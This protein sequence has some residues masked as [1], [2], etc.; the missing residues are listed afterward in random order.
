[1]ENQTAFVR[2]CLHHPNGASKIVET[3]EEE[4]E[5]RAAGWGDKPTPQYAKPAPAPT[6]PKLPDARCANCE[7]ME[8]KFN[9]A[10]N[11]AMAERKELLAR[12]DE[13]TAENQNLKATEQV[14]AQTTTVPTAPAEAEKPKAARK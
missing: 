12:I 4:A 3:P 2:R 14:P 5:K 7:L 8:N 11:K 9:E 6:A 1:M 10:W 13:L